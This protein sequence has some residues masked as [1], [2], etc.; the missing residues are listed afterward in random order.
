M[1]TVSVDGSQSHPLQSV[2][3]AVAFALS[4]WCVCVCGGGGAAKGIPQSFD[5]AMLNQL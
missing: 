4:V 3:S 5:C 2:C 1:S